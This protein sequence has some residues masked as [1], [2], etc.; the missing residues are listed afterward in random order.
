M[1]L[2][3]LSEADP[4]E[5]WRD[6]LLAEMPDLDF[7]IWPDQV[8][9]PD[10]IDVALVWRPPAGVLARYPNLKAILSLGAGIDALIEDGTLPDLPLARMVDPSLTHT[11][12]DYVLSSVLRHHRRFDLFEREQRVGRWTFVFPKATNQRTV[13]IMGLGVLGATAACRLR[14]Q[15]FAVRGWSRSAKQIEG[16]A[17]FQGRDQLPSFLAATEILVCLL[18]LTPDTFGI[19]NAELFAA[20]PEEACLI[21]VGR[22]G[23]LVEDDLIDALDRGRLGAATLDVFETEPLPKTSPL[24]RHE[25]ILITPHVASYC[26]PETAA[27]G[28]IDNIK[29]ARAG[30]PLNH[31]VDRRQGY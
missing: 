14:D 15:G 24:W 7:R 1:A 4:I 25:K 13:G 8:G 20:L 28:V 2:L 12:A 26:V 21:N 23:H 17:C 5:Q 19:L 29:R 3:F 10:D 11:M 31:Q 6:A 9:D 22:G 18:P 16:V 27:A 30:E